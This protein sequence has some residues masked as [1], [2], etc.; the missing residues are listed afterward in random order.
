MKREK[1]VIITP[2]LNEEENIHP[3]IDEVKHALS[4]HKQ[5]ELSF[6]FVDDGSTDNSWGIFEELAKNNKKISALKLSRNFGSHTAWYAGL[7]ALV[8]RGNFDKTVLITVDLQD[9]PELIPQL[10]VKLRGGIRVAWAVRQ[11]REDRGV[12]SFLSRLYYLLVRRFALPAM[13]EGGMD[14]CAF[15]RKVAES[16]VASHEKNTSLLALIL[17]LGY[18]QVTVPYT[19]KSR[20][21]GHSHWSIAKKLK[22]FVDTFVA[23]SYFPIKLLTYLG[24][25]I[26]LMGFGYAGVVF[27]RRLI[28]GAPIE[29]WSS[30]MLV[31]LILSGVQLLM[32]GIVAEYLWRTLDETRKRPMYLIDQKLNL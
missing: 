13:P 11:K 14:F 28:Y 1:V 31:V 12:G 22:L 7:A 9:P 26:S 4:T 16:V 29:G 20:R 3:F 8:E 5:Y 19:R 27:V 2:L 25:A 23:F 6:M 10:L 21:Y 24:F 18:A 15:D 32:L 30:L 17:W